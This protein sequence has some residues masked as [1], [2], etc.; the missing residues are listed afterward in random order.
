SAPVQE[1]IEA[2]ALT[3]LP[4]PTT[5]PRDGGPFITFGP[6]LT[7]APDTHRR[8][9]GLYR[10]HVFDDAT[11]GMHWQSMKGGRG[12]YFEAERRGGAVVGA[13][14]LRGAPHLLPAPLP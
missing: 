9:F 3:R 12:H 10:L 14:H 11:T 1:V 13:A 6:T 4:N 2:P 5:W 8:N 7:E